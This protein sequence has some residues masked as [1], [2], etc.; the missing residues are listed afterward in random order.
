MR[1]AARDAEA[2]VM[3]GG[4]LGI[5]HGVPVSI[6]DLVITKGVRTTWGSVMF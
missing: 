4:A 2:A 5:L 1:A 6:K 3:R